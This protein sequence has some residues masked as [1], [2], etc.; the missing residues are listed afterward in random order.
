MITFI[1]M[2]RQTWHHMMHI[3]MIMQHICMQYAVLQ[4]S[5]VQCRTAV[6]WSLQEMPARESLAAANMALPDLGP[7]TLIKGL[8]QMAQYL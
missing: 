2:L 6:Q 4:C 1:R 8:P 7:F 5:A 3:S